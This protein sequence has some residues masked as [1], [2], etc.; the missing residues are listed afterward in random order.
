MS[1]IKE[2]LNDWSYK[3]GGLSDYFVMLFVVIVIVL[4]FGLFQKYT[5][6]KGFKEGYEVGYYQ[7]LRDYGIDYEQP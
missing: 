5:N 6:D 7:A 1:R 2:I 4:A 3:T